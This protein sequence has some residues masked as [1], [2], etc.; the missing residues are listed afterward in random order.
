[1]NLFFPSSFHPT[2][3]LPRHPSHSPVIP[4]EDPCLGF[5]PIL[6]FGTSG[7]LAA[8]NPLRSHRFPY[9]LDIGTPSVQP[10]H[11]PEPHRSRRSRIPELGLSRRRWWLRHQ[12]LSKCRDLG[13][14]S[15]DTTL[16]C[17]VFKD[18]RVFPTCDATKRGWNTNPGTQWMIYLYLLYVH[19]LPWKIRQ[20]VGKYP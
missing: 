13:G 15:I 2:F 6:T 14:A 9:S 1:M 16:I 18:M 3:L 11:G 20:H 8:L 17:W 19:N 12:S 4:G 10:K 7:C 5:T